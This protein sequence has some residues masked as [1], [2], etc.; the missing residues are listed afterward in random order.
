MEKVNRNLHKSILSLEVS[1]EVFLSG[2][3]NESINRCPKGTDSFL[4]DAGKTQTREGTLRERE[5]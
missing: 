1:R 5:D 4:S 3:W 2:P